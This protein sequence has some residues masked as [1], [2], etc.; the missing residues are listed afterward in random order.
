MQMRRP[1]DAYNTQ[2]VANEYS[3]LEDTAKSEDPDRSSQ[4]K[5]MSFAKLRQQQMYKF[6]NTAATSSAGSNKKLAQSMRYSKGKRIHGGSRPGQLSGE[7]DMVNVDESSKVYGVPG[8]A[9]RAP[10]GR[11]VGDYSSERL[12][13][14][15]VEDRPECRSNILP[16][17]D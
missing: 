14:N 3:G 13:S 9:G 12:R 8:A 1:E 6:Q 4:N 7:E 5:Q 16:S 11:T 2:R 10:F 15:S 17:V